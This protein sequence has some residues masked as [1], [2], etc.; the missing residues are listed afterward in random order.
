MIYSWFLLFSDFY[1]DIWGFLEIMVTSCYNLNLGNLS[2]ERVFIGSPCI[3]NPILEKFDTEV[4]VKKVIL[5][6]RPHCWMLLSPGMEKV[7]ISIQRKL[8][9]WQNPV[10]LNESS[11]M[12]KR[13][14][15]KRKYF[16]SKWW[17]KLSLQRIPKVIFEFY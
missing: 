7:G 17:W 13:V 14:I 9:I 1:W 3:I 15:S 4:L 12:M 16:V 5:P 10:S 6:L 11:K 8:F 2:E